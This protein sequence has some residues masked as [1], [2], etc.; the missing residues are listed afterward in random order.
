MAFN[1]SLM[2]LAGETETSQAI[3]PYSALLRLPG[4]CTDKV[5]FSV[6]LLCLE[7]KTMNSVWV[8]VLVRFCAEMDSLLR[9]ISLVFLL[10]TSVSNTVSPSNLS[11]VLLKS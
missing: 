7:M 8:K 2:A 9:V 6:A 3:P 1:A 5:G 11:G 10:L 4:V